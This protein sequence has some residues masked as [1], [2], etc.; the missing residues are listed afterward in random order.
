MMADECTD[1]ATIEQ[2]S[3]CIQFVNNICEEFLGFVKLD[4]TDAE[5]ISTS[6]LSFFN[7]C[8]LDLSNRHGQ[9]YDGT[10]VMAGKVSGVSAKILQQQPHA[11]YLHCHEHNLNLVVSSSYK[12]VPE[13][14]YLFDS[15]TWFLGACAKSKAILQRYL[16]SDDISQLVAE[17]EDDDQLDLAY[18]LL[19]LRIK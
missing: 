7:S 5:S 8:N 19:K 6:L 1:I 16:K 13:I 14:R 12:Q 4:N 10:S 11:L 2:M 15:L 9:C 18:R 3:V 17:N